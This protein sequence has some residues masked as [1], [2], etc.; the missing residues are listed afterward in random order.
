MESMAATLEEIKHSARYVLVY[1]IFLN[2]N[3][4]PAKDV[5][6]YCKS[7]D[8]CQKVNNKLEAD[9]DRPGWTTP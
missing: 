6:E 1:M 9:R 3:Y 7:C 5:A 4:S 8:I 2:M